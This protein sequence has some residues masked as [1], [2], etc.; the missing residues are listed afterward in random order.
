MWNNTSTPRWW[1]R[2]AGR[3]H[4]LSL[5]GRIKVQ[6]F[7]YLPETIWLLGPFS[8]TILLSRKPGKWGTGM[9]GGQRSHWVR[10][11][12]GNKICSKT[13]VETFFFNLDCSY[14]G[15]SWEV[16]QLFVH[17]L[18]QVSCMCCFERYDVIRYDTI[19]NC[20]IQY[21]TIWC[22]MR[23]YGV[24]WYNAIWYNMIQY[25]VMRCNMIQYD[26][27]CLWFILCKKTRK[28]H[29]QHHLNNCFLLDTT[30]HD[31]MW[32]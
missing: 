20:T 18:Y 13:F 24:I 8:S 2:P 22:D 14:W 30:R 26:T 12:P 17:R 6:F 4:S 27:K 11:I 29:Q 9:L 21:D 5:R 16:S 10:F 1:R 15:D 23:Q 32:N 19:E 28:C 31:M 25:D 7:N 3:R